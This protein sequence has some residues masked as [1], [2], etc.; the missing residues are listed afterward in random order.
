MLHFVFFHWPRADAERDVYTTRLKEFHRRLKMELPGHKFTGSA[1]F[2]LDSPPGLP[3]QGRVFADWYAVDTWSFV[4]TFK[5]TAVGA[6]AAEHNAIAQWMEGGSG[7]MYDTR[8]GAVGLPAQA[9]HSYWF[10]KPKGMPYADLDRMLA[11]LAAMESVTLWQ[12]Q[13]VL[14]ATPEFVMTSPVPLAL[15][16][17]LAAQHR[18]L[19]SDF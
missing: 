16:A 19:S 12:R 8:G 1:V 15:P 7:A 5:E 4:L 18:P 2:E 14:G 11:P 13:L 10:S 3:Y 9:Q 6:V 17:N